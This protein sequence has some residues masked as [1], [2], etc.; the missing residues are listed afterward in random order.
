MQWWL[1]TRGRH[2][3]YPQG[4]LSPETNRMPFWWADWWAGFRDA[5][6]PEAPMLIV[7]TGRDG[8]RMYATAMET[9]RRDGKGRNIRASLLAVGTPGEEK[10]LGLL[11]D[12]WFDGRLAAHFRQ[13]LPEDVIE[14]WLNDGAAPDGVEHAIDDMIFDLPAPP[15]VEAPM[16]GPGVWGGAAQADACRRSLVGQAMMSA[17]AGRHGVFC[18]LNLLETMEEARALSALRRPDVA[19][20]LVEGGEDAEGLSAI[21]EA[22]RPPNPTIAGPPRRGADAGVL[23]TR[24]DRSPVRVGWIV[25]GALA[26][27][28]I[29]VSFFT[30]FA[31][32]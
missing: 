11:I 32:R 24:R 20:L 6:T 23:S 9:G 30:A 22:S 27:V 16:L 26:L 31:Q 3:D 25:A 19:I 21:E 10:A 18:W 12:T 8:W 1:Q 5:T 29:F 13:L 2:V 4:I 17:R 28:S 14:R 15:P 7:E